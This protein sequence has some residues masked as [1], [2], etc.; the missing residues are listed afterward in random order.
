MKKALFFILSLLWG[1]SL[2]AA[3][4]RPERVISLVPSLTKSLYDMGAEKTLVGCTNYCYEAIEDGVEVVATPT[5]ANVEKVVS[6]SPDLVLAS[7]FTPPE[8]V[9]VL[10]KLGIEVLVLANPASFDMI[11]EQFVR[12]G[13]AVGKKA[14][15][16][17]IVLNSRRI[18]DKIREKRAA[19]P[20]EKP[21]KVFFQIGANPIFTVL[22]ASFMN[23]FITFL[24]C[25]NIAS[26]LEQGTVTEEFVLGRRPDYIIITTMGTLAESER[27]KWLRHGSLPASEKA[28]VY[29]V[30]AEMACQP[31]PVTFA[32]TITLLDR[33]IR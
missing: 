28:R 17:Q 23:D 33:L 24:G 15:A 21:H 12:L 5:K 32:Q 8:E 30:D 7:N 18:V 1:L 31:S 26:E 25:E 11:C 16:A 27:L 20:A 29:I 14:R 3:P 19:R 2:I 13:E 10:R 6:L 9:E 22:S 4:G